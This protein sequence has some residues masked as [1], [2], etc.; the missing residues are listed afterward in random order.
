[1]SIVKLLTKVKHKEIYI[2]D[3]PVYIIKEISTKTP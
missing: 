2:G 1:M 3:I